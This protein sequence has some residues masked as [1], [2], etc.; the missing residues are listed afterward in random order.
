MNGKGRKEQ[1]IR[2]FA[3]EALEER[4]I[5]RTDY[6]T[7]WEILMEYLAVSFL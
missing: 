2:L 6:N 7:L 1:G 4:E 5:T 3:Y